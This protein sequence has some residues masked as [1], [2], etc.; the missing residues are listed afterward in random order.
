MAK[1]TYRPPSQLWQKRHFCLWKKMTWETFVLKIWKSVDIY[2]R[3]NLKYEIAKKWPSGQTK[4]RCPNRFISGHISKS[5][6]KSSPSIHNLKSIPRFQSEM[7][8]TTTNNFARLNIAIDYGVNAIELDTILGH[9]TSHKF[10]SSHS[11]V[12]VKSVKPRIKFRSNIDCGGTGHYNYH[13]EQ[14]ISHV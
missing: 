13:T 8:A 4:S 7:R 6:P 10:W 1:K 11:Q 2:I 9:K 5:S 12:P 14:I 3:K